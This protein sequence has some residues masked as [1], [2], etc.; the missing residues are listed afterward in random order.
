MHA[1]SIL[2]FGV[3]VMGTAMTTPDLS[4]T[5]DDDDLVA[6]G[7]ILPSVPRGNSE[8]LGLSLPD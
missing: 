7:E 5:D 8:R 1:L 6:Q 4:L 2:P 3:T